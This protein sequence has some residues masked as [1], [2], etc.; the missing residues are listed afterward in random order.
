MLFK[1]KK[2]KQVAGETGSL[3]K[4]LKVTIKQMKP[5]SSPIP[6]PSGDRERDEIVKATL[7][8]LTLHKTS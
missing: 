3:R 8:S 6:P 2:R 5:S 4:S 7:L 1:K